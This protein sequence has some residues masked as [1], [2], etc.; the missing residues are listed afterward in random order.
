[1]C[2]RYF[3][4]TLL[5]VV[6]ATL[7]CNPISLVNA[8]GCNEFVCGSVVSKCLLTQS[9]QCKLS[10]CYCCKDCLNCLGELYTECCSCLDMCPKH[11][12]T[13][14]ALAPKSQIGDFEGV[15]EYFEALTAEED[16]SQWSTVRF[17]MRNSLQRH[18]NMATGSYG[19]GSPRDDDI[20]QEA[21]IRN[22][23]TTVNCTVIFLNSCMNNKKCSDYC[24]S[25]V[26][27]KSNTQTYPPPQLLRYLYS[28]PSNLMFIP[29][30]CRVPI[31]IVGSMTA[32][33]NALVPIASTMASMRAVAPPVPKTTRMKTKCLMLTI[34]M[35]MLIMLGKMMRICHGIMAKMN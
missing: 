30:F 33:V 1:M 31:A 10:D 16:E 11:N 17:P 25:M 35:M 8:D 34:W 20:D 32:A 23:P 19:F 5:W 15:P 6:L 21:S 14:S 4:F 26:C 12:D 28:S 9:C 29:F 7:C 18:Y 22:I 3:V 24:E 2:L 27:I 13:L